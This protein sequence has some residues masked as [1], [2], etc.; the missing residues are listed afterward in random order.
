MDHFEAII[1]TLLEDE[2]YWVRQSFKFELTKA[3]RAGI[4]RPSMPRVE[5]DL[6]AL[7]R[8][9]DVLLVLEA[10]SFLD[11]PGVKLSELKDLNDEPTG[12]Y[13]IFTSERYRTA[14]LEG[15][16]RD[17]ILQG[18]ITEATTIRLGLVAGKVYQDAC[19]AIMEHMERNGWVFW[20][21]RDV[22]D[23]V[24][25]LAE[26]GYENDPAIIT[27]KILSR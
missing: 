16:R 6:L 14:V 4:G 13:K 1:R 10:K 5:I 20:S 23:R 8:S 19:S 11:S 3:E 22:R 26:R 2:G 9:R 25:R 12:R 15:L 24:R 7:H 17:L 18:M 21:P 27:A